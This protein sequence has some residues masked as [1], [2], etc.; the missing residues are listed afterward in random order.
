MNGEL[1]VVNIDEHTPTGRDSGIGT[2]SCISADEKDEIQMKNPS[3]LRNRLLGIPTGV[4][5]SGKISSAV[6]RNF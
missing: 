2:P 5:Q 6:H 4:R 3:N 1:E